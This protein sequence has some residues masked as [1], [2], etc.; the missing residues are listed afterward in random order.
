MQ[1]HQP[2]VSQNESVQSYPNVGKVSAGTQVDG[3]LQ[4]S[5]ASMMNNDAVVGPQIMKPLVS[6]DPLVN[7]E[8][9]YCELKDESVSST[10]SYIIHDF[11]H[12]TKRVQ[13]L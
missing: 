8:G 10:S 5:D 13:R 12:L 3:D 1:Q 11:P 6:T 7:A 2:T 9:P 4:A